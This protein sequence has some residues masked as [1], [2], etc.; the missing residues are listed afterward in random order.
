MNNGGFRLGVAAVFLL[1]VPEYPP[2]PQSPTKSQS[3]LVAD[4]QNVGGHFDQ[5][6]GTDPL[7][8]KTVF[9]PKDALNRIRPTS[10]VVFPQLRA[11]M[12]IDTRDQQ[13]HQLT[14]CLVDDAEDLL[15]G[16]CVSRCPLDQ[17]SH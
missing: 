3:R 1:I 9:L 12:I 2:V 5:Q 10:L 15:I 7:K 17:V 8:V 4:I 16:V 11:R 6:A 14:G 13:E